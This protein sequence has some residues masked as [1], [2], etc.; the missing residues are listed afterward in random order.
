MRIFARFRVRSGPRGGVS[1]LAGERKAVEAD[2]N[3]QT[4]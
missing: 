1:G 4:N 2:E 3:T